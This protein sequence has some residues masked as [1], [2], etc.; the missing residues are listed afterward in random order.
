[1]KYTLLFLAAMFFAMN[2]GGSG[3]APTFSAAYG[4][5]L[6]KKKYAILLFSVFVLLGAATLGRGVVK[7]LSQGI[8]PKEF[9]NPEV[10][11]VILVSATSSLFLANLLAIPESTSMVTVGAIVGAGL[12]FRHIQLKTFLWLV[13]LWISFPVVSFLI[14]FWLYRYLYPPHNGN[15]WLY[16]KIFSHEKKLRA[17]AIII[18]CYGAFAVGTN[19][20]ANAIGPLAGAGVISADAGLVVLAPLFGAGAFIFGK[21][22]IETFGKEIVPLGLITS[23]IICLVT[24]TLLII[25]SSFGAPFPYVQLNALSVFAISCIKNGHRVTLSHHITKRTFMVWT[26]TPLLSIIVSYFLLCLFVRR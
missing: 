6:I 12:Y 13:P 14:T 4:G 25:A 2:M 3:I 10:A 5:G 20:V 7:T 16:Q 21:H 18:S 11:L 8:L 19:N 26:L 1:M 23:N 15:L 17:L 9:I 24:A 22:N